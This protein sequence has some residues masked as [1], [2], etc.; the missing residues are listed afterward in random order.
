MI[1]R[2]SIKGRLALNEEGPRVAELAAT[3][4]FAFPDWRVDW[5]DVYPHWI[6]ADH[7]GEL[8]GCLQVCYGRPVGRL[9]ILGVDDSLAAPTRAFVVK[10]LLNTGCNTLREYGAQA[11]SGI[12]PFNLKWYMR[13]LKKRGANTLLSGNLML[14][15]LR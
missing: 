8:L 2:R 4:G 10:M 15:R 13:F 5:S 3:C 11:A 14:Y 6:V 7:L 12:I 1:D 9:E